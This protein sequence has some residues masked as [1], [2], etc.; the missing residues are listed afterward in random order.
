MEGL[1]DTYKYILVCFM[2][3]EKRGLY[4]DSLYLDSFYCWFSLF[5]YAVAPLH[6]I[7]DQGKVASLIKEQGQ[8]EFYPTS[9][10][11]YYTIATGN[12]STYGDQLY[13]TLKN[14]AENKGT[15]ATLGS[16]GCWCLLFGVSRFVVCYLLASFGIGCSMHA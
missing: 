9:Q 5:G 15:K 7:Y 8:V 1:T 2:Q 16:F 11:P 12:N 13:V 3:G 6:W 4:L 14:I 10:C